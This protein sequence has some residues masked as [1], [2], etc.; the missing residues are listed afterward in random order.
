MKTNKRLATNLPRPLS[1]G[2]LEDLFDIYLDDSNETVEFMGITLIPHKFLRDNDITA[3]RCS[4]CDWL[5]SEIREGHIREYDGE[6][7]AED[8]FTDA[9]SDTLDEIEYEIRELD[10]KITA[11][12]EKLDDFETGDPAAEPI[13]EEL[14]RL[15]AQRDELNA[16]KEELEELK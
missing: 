6:H 10:D 16:E 12:Q 7:Y 8:D 3:Y 15:E 13:E 2:Q 11:A 5:D 1:E 4:F 9:L 14:S